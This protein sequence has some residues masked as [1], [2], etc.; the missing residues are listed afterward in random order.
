MEYAKFRKQFYRFKPRLMKCFVFLIRQGKYLRQF[1]L[2]HYC[3]IA[4]FGQDAIVLY[5]HN[6]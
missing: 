1:C 6:W 5:I 3:H 2:K 4:L